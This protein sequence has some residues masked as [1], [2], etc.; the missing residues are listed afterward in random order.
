MR[1]RPTRRVQ[2]Q[3]AGE[4]FGIGTFRVQNRTFVGLAMRFPAEPQE[5]GGVVVELPAAAQAV[6]QTGIPNDVMSLIEQWTT[7]GPKI[8]QIVAH[9]GPM[10]D[11]NRP[12][13][14]HASNAVD[15][16]RPSPPG[17]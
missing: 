14:I 12:A 8:K 2:A 4:R 16:L 9:V 17:R 11:T 6:N 5:M 7:V 10:I 13:S 15:A 1:C 3:T